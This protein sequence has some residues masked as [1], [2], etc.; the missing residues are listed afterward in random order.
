MRF[1]GKKMDRHAVI[2]VQFTDAATGKVFAQSQMPAAQL[3][4]SFEAATTVHRP[5]GDW[6]VV[7]A[8][9]ITSAEFCRTGKLVLIL[10][11]ITTESIDPSK[12]LFSLPAITGD[13]L[14][15]IAAGTSKLGGEVIE[16]H[17]DDW[18]Q[19]EWVPASAINAVE[20]ELDSVRGIYEMERE[21]QAFRKCH[22][23][24]SIP[25]LLP[26]CSLQFSEF[27]EAIGPH[28][29]WLAG[30]AY[31]GAAGVVDKSFAVRLLSSIELFGVAYGVIE[32]ICFANTHANNA[33]EPDVRGLATFAAAHDLLLVDWCRV[34]V[35]RPSFADYMSYF[36][37][38]Q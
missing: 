20:S 4:E 30:F 27:R 11:K 18:R 35:L 8:R 22:L 10:R 13:A 38:T 32:S 29:K 26:A 17:E 1:F 3:P 6:S 31:E 7:E 28:V 16:I 5:D 2:H 19:I 37:R 14:P 36:N 34:L 25:A 23:R 24:S 33:P 9:P 15:P 21:G 12:I